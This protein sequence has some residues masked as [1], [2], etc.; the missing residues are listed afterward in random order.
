[1]NTK[2]VKISSLVEK[3]KG[4]SGAD[5]KALCVESGMIAIR[6]KKSYIEQKDLNDACVVIDKKKETGT[7]LTSSPHALYS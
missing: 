6:N 3:T 2:R 1:M 7:R 4:Y 5:L